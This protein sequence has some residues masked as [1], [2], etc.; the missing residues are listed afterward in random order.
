MIHE[1]KQRSAVTRVLGSILGLIAAHGVSTEGD[2]APGGQV[3]G[4]AQIRAAFER[5]DSDKNGYLQRGEFPGSAQQFT[6]ID[7]NKNGRITIEEL[8]KSAFGKL[9]R[10]AR[11]R[12]Q[13]PPRPRLD[14][15]VLALRRLE[16]FRR[17]DTNGDGKLTAREWRGAPAALRAMD[18]DGDGDADRKDLA[19]ARAR[20]PQADPAVFS[21]ISHQSPRTPPS[22]WPSSTV[23]ATAPSTPRRS[24]DRGS[25]P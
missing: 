10:S 13:L 18:L 14:Q 21:A 25:R 15:D 20:V 6:D 23:T 24:A 11:E 4:N 16:H 5:L 22:Y 8:T 2:A 12:N 17:F 7:R 1:S 9:L 19:L 3:Q